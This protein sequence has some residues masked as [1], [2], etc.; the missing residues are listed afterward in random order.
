MKEKKVQLKQKAQLTLSDGSVWEG[1]FFGS[2][3]TTSGEV[4]FNTG[5]VGYPETLTDPSYTGQ[6]LVCT[7]PIVGNYGVPADLTVD[8]LPAF[9]E[10]SNI[11]IRGLIVAHYSENFSHFEAA[12][13]LDAWLQKENIPAITGI[14]TRALTKH[15]RESGTMLGTI[16]AAK[17]SSPNSHIEDP[18]DTNLVASVSI[19]EPTLFL[20]KTA[21]KKGTSKKRVL[22]IDCGAKRNIIRSLIERGVEVR[23]VPWNYDFSKETYDGILISNGPGD[24]TQVTQTIAHVKKALTGSKPI[25]GICLGNQILALAAGAKTFKLPYGHRG[26]NQPCIDV[27]TKRCVI[28]SQNHGY[29]VNAK[30]LPE[31]W[32]EWFVNANDNTNEGIRHTRKPFFSVQFHP[33]ATPGPTDTAY[34]FDEFLKLL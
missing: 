19:A 22:L 24:P 6:I 2:P 15:L 4:V 10:S 34:L 31:G 5:M 28:T 32:S 9:F 30:T 16:S 21:P 1:Y 12:H 3:T 25:F 26:H 7:Y 33:E 14:D 17:K 11:H 18:N 23:A 8:N 20:P 27:R 29:A 13:S